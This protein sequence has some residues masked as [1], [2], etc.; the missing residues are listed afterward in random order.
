MSR[1]AIA[2]ALGAALTAAAGTASAAP[3]PIYQPFDSG[4][5]GRSFR[6]ADV[7]AFRSTL[8][9]INNLLLIPGYGRVA[10]LDAGADLHGYTY[11]WMRPDSLGARAEVTG[12][13]GGQIQMPR[14]GSL[15][16]GRW[17]RYGGEASVYQQPSGAWKSYV[18]VD[19]VDNGFAWR[20]RTWEANGSLD[21]PIYETMEWV[22]I[23]QGYA[24]DLPVLGSLTIQATSEIEVK[25]EGNGHADPVHGVS[26]DVTGTTDA[27]LRL[28]FDNWLAWIDARFDFLG[29]SLVA[30]NEARATLHAHAGEVHYDWYAGF[31]ACGGA[32]G[33]VRLRNLL[34]GSFEALITSGMDIL[35]WD[36]EEFGGLSIDPIVF[37]PD[38]VCQPLWSSPF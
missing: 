28:H 22:P 15:G 18:L 33:E 4:W 13:M 32:R 31:S 5:I 21:H 11:F 36:R 25:I 3:Y 17:M 19:A 20:V 34:K 37:A 2:L 9:N 27:W 14:G 29:N 30:G 23:N 38:P 8:D 35:Y 6:L 26:L 1:I 16:Y 12:W 10:G 24:I 7:G